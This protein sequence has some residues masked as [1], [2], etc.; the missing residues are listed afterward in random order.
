MCIRWQFFWPVLSRTRRRSHFRNKRCIDPEFDV[1]FQE[2][3]FKGAVSLSIPFPIYPFAASTQDQLSVSPVGTA[4]GL[5]PARTRVH[6]ISQPERSRALRPK[7]RR[8]VIDHLFYL[9]KCL[10]SR[11]N[12]NNTTTIV[13]LVTS[14]TITFSYVPTGTIVTCYSSY[15]NRVR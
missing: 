10:C 3:R 12:S 2:R 4:R 5:P 8:Y 6:E 1:M 14:T 15:S 11:I 7:V 13:I 9:P